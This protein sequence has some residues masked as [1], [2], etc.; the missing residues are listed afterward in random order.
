[1]V[2]E[3][4]RTLDLLRQRDRQKRTLQVWLGLL[5]IWGV[6]LGWLAFLGVRALTQ[7]AGPLAAWLTYLV[8]LA[9][10]G[11]VALWHSKRL[12][13]IDAELLASAESDRRH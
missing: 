10:I 1:M 9:A 6:V 7:D 5:V 4:A 3:S 13:D 11:L 2:S 8:P 12:R